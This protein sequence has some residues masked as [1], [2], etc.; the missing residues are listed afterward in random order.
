MDTPVL[1]THLDTDAAYSST[2]PESLAHSTFSVTPYFATSE[3]ESSNIQGK[4][5]SS[6]SFHFDFEDSLKL[7]QSEHQFLLSHQ[8]YLRA[9]IAS[10]TGRGKHSIVCR[11]WLKGMCMKGDFCDFLHQLD[12]ARMPICRHFVKYRYCA[13][14][15]RGVCLFKHPLESTNLEETAIAVGA[16]LSAGGDELDIYC[17]N[18]GSLAEHPKYANTVTFDGQVQTQAECIHYFLGFCKLGPKC[19]KK[20]TPLDPSKLPEMLPDWFLS[21]LLANKEIFPSQVDF[22]TQM[23][24]EK[25]SRDCSRLNTAVNTSSS[26]G[27]LQR[28]SNSGILLKEEGLEYRQSTRK[29]KNEVV[30]HPVGESSKEIDAS[31]EYTIAGLTDA[32]GNTAN[33]T[34]SIKCFIIKCNQMTN[35]YY[36]V[37]FGIWATG[38]SNTRKLCDAFRS[39]QHVVLL[40][41]AN[42]SGGFQGYGRMMSLPVYGLHDGIWGNISVKL[43]GNFRVQWLKQCKVEFEEFGYITNPFNQDLPL[44]K[45]RDGTEL[46]LNIAER[47]CGMMA[48]SPDEDLLAG[49]HLE[50]STR[51][52][53]KT[54]FVDLA[55]KGLLENANNQRD[56]AN[57]KHAGEPTGALVESTTSSARSSI[58][59][60]FNH[61]HEAAYTSV[62]HFPPHYYHNSKT[63]NNDAHNFTATDIPLGIASG[64]AVNFPP[65]SS[66]STFVPQGGPWDNSSFN[67]DNTQFTASNA[68]IN[69]YMLGIS[70]EGPQRRRA[71]PYVNFAAAE[72]Y[73]SQGHYRQ[74][75]AQGQPPH[76]QAR[77]YGNA[78]A[79]LPYP[80]IRHHRPPS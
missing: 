67:Y 21:V 66:S 62:S 1:S 80:M 44:K 46:P 29:E 13:D 2:L 71:A 61:T 40:F 9:D 26:G 77:F 79:S 15:K 6:K 42:E 63:I 48:A 5:F 55:K 65:H 8:G 52:D 43:G 73:P 18:F 4:S 34:D 49:T 37:Q 41:S 74:Q 33:P 69:P 75:Y 25:V 20:H 23:A 14:L 53:H 50:K 35:I 68:D 28:T 54:F 72:T 19:R 64:A 70:E 76:T 59:N 39:N 22:E 17:D 30:S 45:S 16:E 12:Y 58:P 7:H 56:S 11:H 31:T 36:S 10:R 51:I 3:K 38:K 27:G 47:L 57:T 60:Q 24:I 32:L 78:S